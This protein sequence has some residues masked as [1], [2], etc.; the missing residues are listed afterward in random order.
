MNK[1]IKRE[2]CL[3]EQL[4]PKKDQEQLLDEII[5][6]SFPASDPPAYSSLSQPSNVTNPLAHPA[7]KTAI[8]YSVDHLFNYVI[9]IREGHHSYFISH[10]NHIT[11]FGN[12]DSARKAALKEGVRAA[13]MALSKT[14]EEPDLS[15][16]HHQQEHFDYQPLSLKEFRK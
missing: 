11:Q 5:E 6:E 4:N 12:L 1:P 8:F 2:G 3:H 9:E 16:C 15:T 10:K 13:F 7:V 14:Y